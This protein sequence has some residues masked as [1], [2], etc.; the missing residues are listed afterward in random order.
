M[1]SIMG[2]EGKVD[3]KSEKNREERRQAEIITFS[4]YTEYSCDKRVKN[5]FRCLGSGGETALKNID[6]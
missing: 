4:T 3:E 1:A 6:C 5:A 2:R